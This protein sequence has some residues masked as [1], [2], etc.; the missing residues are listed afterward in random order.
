MAACL[1]NVHP[2]GGALYRVWKFDPVSQRLCAEWHR[3][4]DRTI[5]DAPAAA[6]I[7]GSCRAGRRRM[8]VFRPHR[9]ARAA[10]IFVAAFGG[11]VMLAACTRSPAAVETRPAFVRNGQRIEVPA[12]SRLR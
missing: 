8:P 3:D 1:R 7:T 6:D 9:L 10:A 2:C 5:V 11:I 4:G 12:G